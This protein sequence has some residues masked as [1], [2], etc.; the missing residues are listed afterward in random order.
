MY[1]KRTKP[2]TA[3][4]SLATH[5]FYPQNPVSR[6]QTTSISIISPRDTPYYVKYPVSRT[7][8]PPSNLI[9]PRDTPF[10]S[11][12]PV[13]RTQT[14]SISIIYTRDTPYY[15]KYPV[16]RTQI[17][18]ATSFHRATHPFDPNFLYHVPAQAHT[19][20]R[21]TSHSSFEHLNSKTR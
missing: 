6:T 5:P 7:Q 18:P 8:I 21:S 14:T 16:S 11:Q 2:P 20:R 10:Y 15:V 9:S 17:P 3:S 12:N 13:S 19:T 1:R 4:F